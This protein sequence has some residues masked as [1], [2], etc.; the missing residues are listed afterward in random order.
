MYPALQELIYQAE[1]D[2]LQTEDIE[3]LK[4]EVSTLKQRINV[5]KTLRDNEVEIFQK[6]ANQ[7]LDKLPKEKLNEIQSCLLQWLSITRYCSM[8][9]ILNNPEFLERRLLEW[10][11][12]IVEVH[13]TQSTSQMLHSLLMSRLGEFLSESDITYI[14]PFLSQANN[15][16]SSQSAVTN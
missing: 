5:Y 8:A 14:E 13:Q 2:Y 15:Y 7:L 4:T 10:L 16:L 6:I 3:N 12:D 1:C 11:T 9:M